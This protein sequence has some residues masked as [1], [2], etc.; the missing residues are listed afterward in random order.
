MAMNRSAKSWLLGL[1][2]LGIVAVSARPHAT[3]AE[4]E[5]IRIGEKVGEFTFKDIRYLPRTLE[6]LGEKKAYVLVFTTLECPL[7]QRYL[8]V[9]KKLDD[10]FRSREVQF[11][12][13][14]VGAAD[15]LMEVAWQA[16][17]VDAAFPF[18]KDYDGEV[19]RALGVT[20]T[21]EAVVLDA[22]RRLRYRGRIDSQFR[23]GGA[24]PNA[25]REDLREAI[26][27]VLG[28]QE[29]SVASTPVDGCLIQFSN[30]PLPE[31]PITYAEQIAPLLKEHCQSCHQGIGG[32]A[33]SLRNYDE[34]VS[35]AATIAEVVREGRMPPWYAS[36][37]HGEFINRRGLSASQR[38]LIADW[39]RGGCALGDESK[40]PEPLSRDPAAWRIGPPDLVIQAA[41][42]TRLPAT[43]IMPYQYILLPHLFL[44]DT[45][46]QK[47]EIRPSNPKAVHHCNMAFVAIGQKFSEANFITGQVPGGE[48]FELGAGIGFKIPAYSLLALQV[49]YVPTGEESTDRISVGLS[50]PRETI[51]KQLHHFQIVNRKFAITPGDGHHAVTASRTL[52]CDATGV[53]MFVHMHV[54]GKD[55]QFLA[56]KP[57]GAAET[58][59]AVPNYSFDWQMPYVWA[60][61][62]QRFPRGTRIECLAHFDN[63]AFN[64]YNP[65]P[66][67][68][69]R[70]GQQTHEEMMM[71]FFFYT[72]DA[73]E[74]NLRTDPKTGRVLQKSG[75]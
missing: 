39:V 30:P 53:G 5:D 65:D 21:P 61:G 7:V 68:T 43:G 52:K 26:E 2:M 36:R 59:L 55:M 34:V 69:V 54:R 56:H 20:R 4:N 71:G 22:R 25:G 74:L 24:R 10:E 49:H 12:A 23:L 44:A 38:R 37:E 58:L 11:L 19:V 63:S 41:Q 73:E 9:V 6:E 27:E 40:I 13:V 51:Q 67:A 47:A 48:A 50:Y 8:P 46:I 1:F 28:G 75:E 64:P 33:F 35:H 60:P 14:N 42:T 15:P 45:W 66:T 16:V 18:V 3:A 31:K 70:E 29:V 32:G 72:D 57:D 62:K 17:R